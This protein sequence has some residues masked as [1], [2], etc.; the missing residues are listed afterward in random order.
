[1]G[2]VMNSMSVNR[3]RVVYH[4]NTWSR[5]KESNTRKGPYDHKVTAK[6]RSYKKGTSQAKGGT[7]MVIGLQL[8]QKESHTHRDKI[9]LWPLKGGTPSDARPRKSLA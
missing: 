9:C 6:G 3:S 4:S 7:L 1:M 2:Y 8:H 5:Q